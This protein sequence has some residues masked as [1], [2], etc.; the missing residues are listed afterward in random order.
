MVY[1]LAPALCALALLSAAVLP[2][3]SAQESSCVTNFGG[4]CQVDTTCTPG[5]GGRRPGE[6][7][8][9]SNVQCCLNFRL[10]NAAKAYDSNRAWQRQAADVFQAT[11]N[12]YP[13]TLR[14]FACRYRQ[15]AAPP[16][17]TFCGAPILLSNAL[18]FFDG[19]AAHTTALNELQAAIEAWPAGADR[20]AWQTFV[21]KFRNLPAA[22]DNDNAPDD[23]AGS[24]TGSNAGS[25]A[26]R[27]ASQWS[28]NQ[29]GLGL[30]TH[31][32]GW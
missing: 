29:N 16:A 19:S 15:N 30:I 31:F 23:S 12:K 13:A 28:L 21:Q 8:G 14:N 17:S 4:S 9:A 1:F 32:E 5:L 22:A 20:T 26:R 27:P 3:A 18:N 24:D 10:V 6:C 11:L 2:L 25:C 7:P